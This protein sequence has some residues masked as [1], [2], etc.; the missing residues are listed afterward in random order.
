MSSAIAV[1]VRPKRGSRFEKNSLFP[2]ISLQNLHEMEFQIS[3]EMKIPMNFDHMDFLQF[4]WLHN[5]V[6]RKV[7]ERANSQG[8]LQNL[9]GT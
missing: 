4:C 2:H 6:L 1:E 5:R 3:D 7:K 8:G 9:L